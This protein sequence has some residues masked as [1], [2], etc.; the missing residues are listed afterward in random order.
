MKRVL[1]LM[2]CFALLGLAPPLGAAE[3]DVR[4]DLLVVDLSTHH[5]E[6]GSR[7]TGA[8]LIMFGATRSAGDVVVVV[9][10]PS[11]AVAVRRKEPT[12]GFWFN[13]DSVEFKS[14]PLYYAYAASAPVQD[15]LPPRLLEEYQIGLDNVR[16]SADESADPKEIQAARDAFFRAQVRQALYTGSAGVISFPI[17]PNLF[18]VNLEF[19]ANIPTGPYRVEVLLVEGG[20]VVA[21]RT[22]PLIVSKIG[23][24]AQLFVFAHRE[25]AAYAGI[26]IAAALLA[27]WL[28]YIIFRK[29]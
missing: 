25:A 7:F 6:I 17:D 28:G 27:G 22:T 5:I 16:L 8:S 20:E 9:R 12:A 29:V 11:S 15:I 14:V 4:D 13:K 23:I 19:P 26:A 10:G 21:Q 1:G 24:A 2:L 3:A 18:R